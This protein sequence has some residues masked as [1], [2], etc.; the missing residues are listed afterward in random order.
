MPTTIATAAPV[1]TTIATAAPVPTT[2]YAPVAAGVTVA[3]LLMFI[4]FVTVMVGLF[5]VKRRRRMK[6]ADEN[7]TLAI[8]SRYCSSNA[9]SCFKTKSLCDTFHSIISSSGS[10]MFLYTYSLSLNDVCAGQAQM[11]ALQM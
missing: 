4:A 1:P 5:W 8:L 3:L 7:L 6:A 10:D 9:I 11:S 2:T